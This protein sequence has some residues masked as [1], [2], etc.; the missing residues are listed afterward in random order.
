MGVVMRDKEG[1]EEEGNNV[2]EKKK[3]KRAY[4]ENEGSVTMSD[5]A[6][7]NI[8]GVII[9]WREGDRGEGGG[10]RDMTG[11]GPRRE[12]G[13]VLSFL[14]GEEADNKR[15]RG[16]G[17]TTKQIKCMCIM[18]DKGEVG[19]ERQVL[20]CLMRGVRCCNLVSWKI[21]VVYNGVYTSCHEPNGYT[22]DPDGRRFSWRHLFIVI[23]VKDMSKI[24]LGFTVT[25]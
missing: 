8:S 1:E 17:N 15:V 6:C 14:K 13:I 21:V 4:F 20:L 24:F 2:E 10:A 16:G 5:P 3:G 19:E 11:D 23:T 9:W 22:D 18:L 25:L 7:H 12:K